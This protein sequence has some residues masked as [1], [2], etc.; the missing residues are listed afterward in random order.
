MRRLLPLLFLLFGLRPVPAQVPDTAA[1]AL[2]RLPAAGLVLRQDWRYHP[3]DN[4]AWARPEFD[5]RA[6]DTIGVARPGAAL[7][8]RALGGIG[9]FRLRLRLTD[10]LRYQA[11]GCVMARALGAAEVYCNGRRLGQ[12]GTLSA[13]P[14]RVRPGGFRPD[15]LDLPVAERGELLL[16][17]RFA[18]WQPPA[19]LARY[20]SQ[21]RLLN[22]KLTLLPQPRIRFQEVGQSMSMAIY[23]VQ[24]GVFLLLGLLHLTFYRYNRAQPAN[25]YFALYALLLAIGYLPVL[26]LTSP[27][28]GG[29][30]RE[31]FLS[32][33]FLCAGCLWGLRALYALFEVRPGWLYK[34]LWA[35][36]LLL[37]PFITAEYARGSA[38]GTAGLVAFVVLVGGEQLRLTVQAAR[39]RRRGARLIGAGFALSLLCLLFYLFS[40]VFVTQQLPA[41]TNAFAGSL[42]F[43]F[44]AL[45]ISLYLAREFALDARLL[46]LKLGEVERLSAQTLAQE[47]EKQALLARQNETLETQVQQRTDALQRSLTE[48]RATQA[49]LIQSEKMASL[50]E[51]TAGIAHEIQNPLNFVNNFADVS[52]ELV[53][54]LKEAQAAG[55]AEEVEALA[56]DLA[57]NLG[58]IHQHGQ[59]AA[60]IVRGMLEHSRQ[61]SGERAPTDLNALCEE[62]LRL[63][64]H[65]LRAKDKTFNATLDTDLA[66]GLPL[67]PASAADLGRVLLNLLNNAFYA[68][69]QRQQRG[70]EPG[71][72]PTVG[73]STRLAAGAVKIRVRDNGTGIPEEVRQKIFQPFFTTKP[74]GEG[75]GLG[76]SLS[77]DIVTKGHGGTLDVDSEVNQGTEFIITLPA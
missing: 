35:A 37:V 56:E 29:A 19:P 2:R 33:V 70:T 13:D 60:G 3:G 36:T 73:V 6:W 44:P 27:D 58:R 39:R 59:R 31:Y 46:Q 52:Q 15:P 1:L 42:L 40:A 22:V 62:Y 30:L 9:W 75:T 50:G 54:E 28:L 38:W 21:S 55:D 72:Q 24:G 17:V 48:L 69:Q 47:Q 4:P 68:V 51:L 41:I 43:F 76:L 57:Q 23:A 16:A 18:P 11:L 45:G 25:R 7:P 77:Y 53:Q 71:Y 66:L 14:A 8:T 74:T 10:S 64:Y 34:S 61:S 67:V 63:A 5:D 12:Y 20:I 32:Y 49:Q 65:G 26:N